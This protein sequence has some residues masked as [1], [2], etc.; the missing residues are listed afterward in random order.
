[1]TQPYDEH[2]RGLIDHGVQPSAPLFDILCMHIRT[3]HY[4]VHFCLPLRYPFGTGSSSGDSNERQLL[5]ISLCKEII[6]TIVGIF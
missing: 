1:M 6:I 2:R 5:A 4:L 3:L